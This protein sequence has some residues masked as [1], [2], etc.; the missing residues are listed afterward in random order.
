MPTELGSRCWPEMPGKSFE[1][2]PATTVSLP[3]SFAGA[4][5]LV[6]GLGRFGGGVGVTRWLVEQGAWVTVTD[7]ADAESLRDSITEVA[8]PRVTLHLGGHDPADLDDTDCVIVNPAVHKGKSAFFQ[9]VLRRNL[10]W[11]TEMN[12]FCER[13][14]APVIGVTGSFGKS[15]TSAML[16]AVLSR[17]VSADPSTV[18][19]LDTPVSRHPGMRFSGAHL[20]G[21]IGQSL[22]GELGQI[23]PSDVVVLEMSNAQLEDLPRMG[24]TPHIAVITNLWPHH[25][26]RYANA[27]EYFDAKLN[28]ITTR[29]K[30]RNGRTPHAKSVIAGELCPQAEA[31]FADRL[32]TLTGER[33]SVIRVASP[34]VPIAL[35][36]PGRHNQ[37]NAACVMTVCRHMALD[38]R[39][40]RAALAEFP[41]LPHRLE[42]V[43]TLDGVDYFNDS[44][45]TAPS[46][47]LV[48]VECFDRPLVLILGGQV[49]EVELSSLV[50][51]V[52]DR[53][54]AVVCMGDARRQFGAALRQGQMVAGE[55]VPVTECALLDEAIS[56]ARKLA[57]SGDVVLFSPGAPSFDAYANFTHRGDHFTRLVRELRWV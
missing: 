15:T 11:T 34:D 45:S 52:R 30:E 18:S 7:Q 23:K 20:G 10:P 43:R 13:C 57:Q 33:P 49:K 14:P 28:I 24:W 4:R 29:R 55:R 38:E 2:Q 42:F 26:D 46:A 47:T 36:I 5:V 53:C 22:L 41:G 17:F 50:A 21:N 39:E 19:N 44:K 8:G 56:H 54:R 48:A 32:S 31:L 16:A 27:A 37:A 25:L 12:L 51:T 40:V 6:I 1:P 9:E 35:R 3:R